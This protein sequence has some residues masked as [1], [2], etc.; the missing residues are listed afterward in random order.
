MPTIPIASKTFEHFNILKVDAG[1]NCPCGGDTGHGG[2]TLIR[3]TNE[4]STDMR[5]R[6][7]NGQQIDAQAVEIVFGG[8]AECETVIQA[9]E[10][11]LDALK[12]F[13]D[14]KKKLNPC[15]EEIN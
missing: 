5:V 8:D 3:F 9:L 14:S 15:A 1:T 11:M 7:D 12:K 10:F 2:R 13:V 4:A 6:V